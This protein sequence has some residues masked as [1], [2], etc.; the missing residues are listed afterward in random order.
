[1]FDTQFF[2]IIFVG[3]VLVAIDRV[4]DARKVRLIVLVVRKGVEFAAAIAD[5][6]LDGSA[7]FAAAGNAFGTAGF[8][9]ALDGF[10][11]LNDSDGGLLLSEKEKSEKEKLR[12]VRKV[13]RPQ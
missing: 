7:A 9:D 4:L 1:M 12:S 11:F 13:D 6:V 10:R 3:F 5:A 8:E 2:E